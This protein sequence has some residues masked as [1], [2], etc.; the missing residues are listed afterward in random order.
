MRTTVRFFAIQLSNNDGTTELGPPPAT[1]AL[2][3]VP[4]SF[5]YDLEEGGPHTKTHTH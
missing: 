4:P 1:T 5:M 2:P 3:F